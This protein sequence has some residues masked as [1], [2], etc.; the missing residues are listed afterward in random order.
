MLAF[1]KLIA[2]F[3]SKHKKIKSNNETIYGIYILL[4]APLTTPKVVRELSRVYIPA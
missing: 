2:T 1:I 4:V 3:A